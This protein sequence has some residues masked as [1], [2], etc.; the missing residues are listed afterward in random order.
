M[1]SDGVCT[2]CGLVL[3][4]DAAIVSELSFS[5][6]TAGLSSVVG[7]FVSLS[8]GHRGLSASAKRGAGGGGLGGGGSG[9]GGG[10]AV[11]GGGGAG[12]SGYG[13][14]SREQTLA[15]GRKVCQQLCDALRLKAHHVEASHR[16]FSLAV[17]HNFIQGRRTRNVV[18]CCLYIVCRRERTSHLLLDFADVLQTN[19]YV[20]G[21]TLLRFVRL[22]H[23][24]L[25]IIDPSLYIHRFAA[26]L[27]LHSA[28]GAAADAGAQ[29][30]AAP[31]PSPASAS[32]S[33]SASAAS[34]PS[35][36]ASVHVVAMTALRLVARMKRDWLQVG[37]RPSGIC[38]A[39]LL[40]A[41][42]LH[43]YRRSQR[44]IVDV[45]RVCDATLRRRLLEFLSTSSSRQTFTDFEADAD[46]ESREAASATGAAAATV[47][48]LSAPSLAAEEESEDPPAFTRACAA[49]S[50]RLLAERH[51]AEVLAQLETRGIVEADIDKQWEAEVEQLL[52]T[53]AF[54]AIADKQP[55][56]IHADAKQASLRQIIRQHCSS[57]G[58]GSQ[59][60]PHSAIAASAAAAA[61]SSSGGDE[62]GAALLASLQALG[63]VLSPP[64]AGADAGA[65]VSVSDADIAEYLLS[66]EEAA[67]KT[68]MW[69]EIHRDYIAQQQSRQAAQAAAQQQQQQ[70]AAATAAAVA[71]WP[72]RS[73]LSG[74]SGEV[75]DAEPFSALDDAAQAAA[76]SQQRKP[77]AQSALAHKKE[78]LTQ[79]AAFLSATSSQSLQQQQTTSA[80]APSC[81]APADVK[82][83]SLL[84]LSHHRLL[85]HS[86]LSLLSAAS[87][88]SA[89]SSSSAQRPRR[90]SGKLNYQRLKGLLD[91]AD[92]QPA[93]EQLQ[94]Q[95][96]K[97]RRTAAQQAQREEPQPHSGGARHSLSVAALYDGD[98]AA[99]GGREEAEAAALYQS[100]VIH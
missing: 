87:S 65:V 23:I 54:A 21:A 4:E 94:P 85:P 43:G 88:S 64:S 20:L 44:E 75:G 83:A 39:C 22:L 5:E 95:D 47:A 52:S 37:R 84:S 56:D 34:P 33:S 25:P 79:S 96:S 58:S 100:P 38:G 19:L 60:A 71:A 15:V 8:S 31:A 68:A 82:D 17:Q 72:A 61:A 16:Y 77:A 70:T 57:S 9:G 35:P 63:S 91:N 7:Q 36:R 30:A 18:A 78:K 81:A 6:N 2:G 50:S 14:D 97:R 92:E 32:S 86:S 12:G 3:S 46:R 76:A 89:S 28:A 66:E 62:D 10:G 80:A 41:C 1:D 45:V 55:V 42:R 24:A 49:E 59:P 40:I 29:S 98:D 53:P 67:F 13:R 69:D 74:S 26:Q 48:G 51:R 11:L 90:V 27:E 99:A 93:E 73:A